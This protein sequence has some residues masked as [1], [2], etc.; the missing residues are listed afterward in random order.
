MVD[1][2]ATRA[3]L[4]LWVSVIAHESFGRR[5]EHERSERE[6]MRRTEA[7]AN[8][9]GDAS[10]AKCWRHSNLDRVTSGAMAAG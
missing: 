1:L 6:S 2:R 5:V 7:S 10:I 8:V 9:G 4:R 3:I